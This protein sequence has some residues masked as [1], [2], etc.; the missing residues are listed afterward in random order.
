MSKCSGKRMS[1]V[2]MR[3]SLTLNKLHNQFQPSVLHSELVL[4]I[5]SLLNLGWEFSLSHLT[6]CVAQDNCSINVDS[7]PYF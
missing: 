4:V 3:T 1:S 6:E 2:S 5:L 7:H